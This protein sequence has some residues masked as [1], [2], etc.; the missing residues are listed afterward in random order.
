MTP[1]PA[2]NTYFPSPGHSPAFAY[3]CSSQRPRPPAQL[4]RPPS[5]APTTDMLA[6]PLACKQHTTAGLCAHDHAHT[7]STTDP[8]FGVQRRPPTQRH[9]RRRSSITCSSTEV[10]TAPG[11]AE[12]GSV[13]RTGLHSSWAKERYA[14]RACGSCRRPETGLPVQLKHEGQLVRLWTAPCKAGG[15]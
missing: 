3:A 7:L 1:P 2:S 8:P 15:H 9:A 12:R 11:S 4:R 13:A 10:Y 5:D 14:A 6:N